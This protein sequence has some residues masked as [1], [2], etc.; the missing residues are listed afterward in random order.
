MANDILQDALRY[1]RF[2]WSVIPIKRGTKE[3][4]GKWKQYQAERASIEQIKKWFGNG[5]DFGVAV[6]AGDVSGGLVCR[7]FDE[8]TAYDDWT[9]KYP[10]FAETLPTVETGRPGRHVYC[11]ADIAQIRAARPSKSTIIELGDGE[12]RGGGYCILPP[13]KHPTG[14]VYRALLPFGDS[15]PLLDMYEVGFLP[16][17]DVIEN[18]NVTESTE[19]NRG[20]Q[21][22]TEAI[23]GGLRVEEKANTEPDL[24][25]SI[26][27]PGVETAILGSL[28]SGPGWRNKHVFELA[29]AIKA[30]P[31]LADVP[32]SQLDEL[33]PFVRRW[34]ELALPVIQTK[35]FEETWIDFLRAWPR[36]KWAKGEGPMA[37]VFE[38]AKSGNIPNRA[39]RYEQEGLQL[40]VAV[41]RELQ[42]ATGD[43][44]FFL[45][46]RTA[47]RLLGVTP[48]H[49]W[50]WLF[51]LQHDRI[52]ELVSRGGP[53]TMKA[54]RYR[55]LAE[56]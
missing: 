46:A 35:P 17:C 19:G 40:L 42:R 29:R 18:T 9:A 20:Q 2:C 51:L 33:K 45:S 56:L 23:G 39:R 53:K 16:P 43:A 54:S 12:L 22:T 47:G 28:P 49:A 50:R 25:S 48:T 6:V 1:H 36:V 32:K 4:Y 55:Y 44:P 38:K 21:R 3:P 52:L 27:T 8:M 37:Q 34:H 31:S 13:S 15:L 41:C 11:R 30:I 5:Q 14:H 7:D 26:W 24:A 10:D